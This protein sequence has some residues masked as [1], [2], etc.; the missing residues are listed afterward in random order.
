MRFRNKSLFVL[1]VSCAALTFGYSALDKK[2]SRQNSGDPF[3]NKL[4]KQYSGP[5]LDEKR[6]VFEKE[7]ASL[8]QKIAA[9]LADQQQRADHATLAQQH[10]AWA[11]MSQ[12][13][14]GSLQV[15]WNEDRSVPILIKGRQLQER[16]LQRAA[17]ANDA[18]VGQQTQS[19]LQENAELL[20]I[21]NPEL[22]FALTKIEHDPYGL[23]HARYQQIYQ[24][25]EVWGRNLVV[26]VNA[27]GAVESMNGRYL[28][29]PNL[30][31]TE[32]QLSAT[33]AERIARQKFGTAARATFESDSRKVIYV[34]VQNLARIAW[35]VQLRAGLEANWHYFIDAQSGEILH[36]YNHVMYDGPAT[37]TGV[38]LF[39]RTRNLN[40]YQIGSP[41]YLINASKPMFKPASSSFPDKGEGVI[42]TFDV[43]NGDGGQL[44]YVTSTNPN[45][46]NNRAAVSAAANGALVYDYYL[47]IHGRNAIDASGSTMNLAVNF[48]QNYNNA[49]WNGQVMVFGNGDGNQFS[50]LA[51]AL[52]VTAHEMSHGVVENTA[53]LVYENQPGAL[54]ESFADVFGALF[55]FWVEGN[56]GDWL[57]GEDVTTPGT[58]GDALR[59]MENPASNRV[60]FGGQPTRMSE[61][62]NLP[63]TEAGDNGG[64]HINSGIPNRAFYLYATAV[65]RAAAE[66]VY[67]QALANYLTRNAQFI[68]CR[69]A[70][71]KA[72]ED[73]YGV[74]SAQAT[75]AG[76]AFDVVEIL[77][78]DGTPPPQPQPPVQGTEYLAIISTQ[79]GQLYRTNTNGQQ[80]VLLSSQPLG[81][82]PAVTD[83]GAYVLYVDDTANLH[84]VGSDG[85]NDQQIT[86]SGVFN[87]VSISPNGRFLAVTTTLGQPVIFIAD[88]DSPNPAFTPTQLYTPT[89]TQGEE[90]GNILFPDRIDWASDNETLMYDAFNIIVD[91]NGDTTGYWDINLLRS[92]DGSI[93]RLF[94]PQ[95]PGVSIGNAVFASNTDNVIAFDFVDELGN[96]KVVAVNLNTGDQGVVTNNFSSLGSPSFSRDDRRVYYHYI[97]NNT[98]NV[99]YVNLLPDGVT[100][101][102]ND[103]NLVQGGVFPVSFTVGTRPSSVESKDG[104]V[105]NGFALQQNYP[106]PFNPET[107]IRYSLPWP[108]KVKLAVFD[109]LGREVVTLV[110]EQKSAGEALVIWSGRDR[111]GAHLGSGIYF[112]RLQATSPAGNVT[113]M[114]RKMTLLK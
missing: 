21:K 36:D 9:C 103:V 98:A 27:H 6:R 51:A 55:E 11:R 39:N 2:A 70:V 73:I 29:T 46:W 82:R 92:S 105:P 16:A 110:D 22:E 26:H 31:L 49:F 14:G 17:L 63:N 84:L 7:L 43:R 102:G 101:D 34:D 104:L 74:G 37:G 83:D 72:A 8:P 41:Y 38:D 60:A 4:R 78:G 10:A 1:T 23:V 71:I 65:G 15:Y 107:S 76:Q 45:S 91:S 97:E 20:R 50:D 93:A 113:T 81:S 62:Q 66:R 28:P 109:Q 99:W 54:N 52:D 112:Y 3:D 64:V 24:G 80:R 30:S 69:L 94:P 25:L 13:A 57:I 61:F 100:G 87:N 75:A 33:Q 79:N 19:F 40:I 12:I 47:Q 18:A 68:D 96:V 56:S 89:Y 86:N 77:S 48:K 111:S 88:L 32:A 114:T 58:V 85:A 44:Y 67:Y 35:L 108:A 59:D 42:Y 106:N 95:R 53:N 5:N 90:A